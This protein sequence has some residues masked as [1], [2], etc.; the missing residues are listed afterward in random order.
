MTPLI[1]TRISEGFQAAADGMDATVEG[2]VKDARP[3]VASGV[4]RAGDLV[5][6]GARSQPLLAATLPFALRD[7]VKRTP[8]FAPGDVFIGNDPYAGGSSLADLRMFAPLFVGDEALFFAGSAVRYPDM[9][10]RAAGGFSPGA[11]DVRQEGVRVPWTRLRDRSGEMDEAL[12]ELLAANARFPGRLRA[13]LRAQVAGLDAG[14]ERLRGLIERYGAEVVRE[15]EVEMG[16]RAGAAMGAGIADLPDGW[17]A[18]ED[19]LDGDGVR[20]RGVRLIVGAEVAGDRLRLSFEGSDGPCVGP[21]NCGGG[22][23][24]AACRVA[25]R[26]LFPEVAGHTAAFEGVEVVLPEASFV[27]ALAPQPVSGATEVAGR[28]AEAV[29]AALAQADPAR[30]GAGSFASAC[31][32]SLHGRAEGFGDYLMALSLGGGLGACIR[33]DGLTNGSGASTGGEMPSLEGLEERYPI[34]VLEYAVRPGSGGAGRYRGGMGAVFA[35]EVLRGEAVLTLFG[36]RGRRGAQGLRRGARGARARVEIV[37]SSG[38]KIQDSRFKIETLNLESSILNLE[39]HDDFTSLKSEGVMLGAGDRV[40]VETPGGGGYG[41]P[42]E[43][44]IR[45]VTRDVAE[46]AL[47]RREAA[48]QHGVIFFEGSLDYDSPKTF[49]LR[50]YPLS[51]ADIEGILDELEEG[52]V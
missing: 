8:G 35:F 9:G 16:R 43:R 15:A 5:A 27:N 52:R 33:G 48:V 42:Y 28:V 29:I 41:H 3:A 11:T 23:T 37:K 17:Y 36:D 39:S 18:F 30:A 44:A 26:H 20:D 4:C 32:V 31:H 40:R 38:F 45:L 19:V 46:G 1:F 14:L 7:L 10:G 13:L 49:Q 6:Q 24:E 2:L 12:V 47:T 25:L 22:L 34:R 51:V 50:S 21:L